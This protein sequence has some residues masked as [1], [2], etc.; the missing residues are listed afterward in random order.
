MN[1]CEFFHLV[2]SIIYTHK[3]NERKLISEI[4][5]IEYSWRSEVGGWIGK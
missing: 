1:E 3:R 2:K 4:L 5:S